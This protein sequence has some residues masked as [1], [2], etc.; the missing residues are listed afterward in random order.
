MRRFAMAGGIAFALVAAPMTMVAGAQASA[1]GWSISPAVNP[2]ASGGQLTAVACPSANDCTAVGQYSDRTGNQVTLAEQWNGTAWSIETTPLP[3]NQVGGLEAVACS[4]SSACTA[5]G[6]A[7]DAA[8]IRITLIEHWNGTAWA[9]QPTPNPAGAESSA[10][11]GVACAST[12][13]CTAVGSSTTSAGIPE[14]LAE[15]WNGTS[16]AIETT[17]NPP[18]ATSSV[19]AAVACTSA[20]TCSAV[21]SDVTSTAWA[22]TNLA[23]QNQGGTWTIAPTPT[24]LYAGPLYGVSCTDQTHCVAVGRRNRSPETETWNGIAWRMEPNHLTRASLASVSCLSL[25]FCMAAGS[26]AATWN[27]GSWSEQAGVPPLGA[28]GRYVGV[29]CGSTTVH[30]GRQRLCRPTGPACRR[31]L[32]RDIVVD[33]ASSRSRLGRLHQHAPGRVLCVGDAVHRGRVRR[34]ARGR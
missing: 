17:P 12:S 28:D 14:T 10:F 34:D 27:G 31:A 29:S 32:E 24:A 33:P 16:W 19:L 15:Q 1:S 4:A 3:A 25:S 6:Y 11:A 18:G 22:G 20:T 30:T 23:E 13:A 8:G 2:T 26:T 5:A 21:G 9:I 7:Y